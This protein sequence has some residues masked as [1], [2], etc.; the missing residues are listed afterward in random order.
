M[1]VWIWLVIKLLI[2]RKFLEPIVLIEFF[3]A[4]HIALC[5]RPTYPVIGPIRNHLDW[6]QPQK[7]NV[8]QPQPNVCPDAS[9]STECKKGEEA[10]FAK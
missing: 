8:T 10:A 2:T 1:H 9:A 4:A 7:L 5:D 6:K 3:R